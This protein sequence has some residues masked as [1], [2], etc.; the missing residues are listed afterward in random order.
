MLADRSAARILCLIASIGVG[1]SCL[2][3]VA[4]EAAEPAGAVDD[5]SL[6]AELVFWQSMKDTQN[7]EELRAYLGAYPEGRF[8][9][10]ARARLKAL[11]GEAGGETAG[12]TADR[13]SRMPKDP[14]PGTR[15]DT[16]GQA[17]A[18]VSQGP[19][20]GFRDCDGCPPMVVVPAG[21][22]DMG[23]NE[24]GSK[25]VHQV[26][27]QRP[28]AI[29]I[30]EVTVAQWE[31]CMTEGACR[32]GPPPGRQGNLPVANVSWEDAQSYLRWLS[33]K[34]GR[35]YR[36]PSEAEWEYAARAGTATRYWWGNEKAAGRANCADCGSPWDGRDASPVGSFQ[37]NPFGLFDVHG[38][39]W[40]WTQ[41]CWIETYQGAPGDG[42]PRLVGDCLSRVI[43][44]GSWALDHE[45][46]RSSRR[47]RY[48]R[49]VRYH[50]NG[51]RVVSE[52]PAAA[53]PAPADGN[54]PFEAAVLEAANRVFANA[55]AAVPGSAPET[56]VIDPLVDGLTGAES[57]ATRAIG[58]RVAALVRDRYAQFGVKDF[59]AASA[60]SRYVVV[61][62]FTGVN[63]QRESTGVREA[64][65]VCLR[66]LDLEAGKVVSGA[67]VFASPTGV[68]ITPTAFFRD[69]PVWL[70]DPAT[71]A[72]IDSCQATKPGDPVDRSYSDR[73]RAAALLKEAIDAYEKEEYGRSRDLFM[74]AAETKEGH[75]LRT[76][77]GLYLTSWKLGE[78]RQ[79]AQAFAKLVE[80]GLDNRRLGVKFPFS[81]GSTE[82]LAAAEA[83]GQPDLWLAQIARATAPRKDC[84]EIV[85]HTHRSAQEMLDQRL[86]LQRAEYVMRRLEAEAPELR[87]R[88][89]ATGKGSEESRIGTGTADARD[90]LDRRIE[91]DAIACSRSASEA[92]NDRKPSAGR[93]VTSLPPQM[94]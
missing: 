24:P 58:S 74:R 29:G 45:Y 26:V 6:Q 13:S 27:I 43:R 82:W 89:I 17:G 87:A 38:N 76:Y 81:P 33:A 35:T 18:S 62:T 25:P 79:A 21:R 47:S 15:A 65:R 88:M 37:P 66:L 34:T 3:V 56:V 10:L 40:E 68:D 83:D 61:G 49:D 2:G 55:P 91:L 57:V 14:L 5:L 69:S 86:S 75:Q 36:L 84:L 59:S 1:A 67:K 80:Y 77:N 12:E 44:G 52:L 16:G 20:T 64:Y 31:A 60:A 50:L 85:G 71:Q 51:F 53:G 63:K 70:A 90:A 39:V 46:M 23:S 73:I 30:H 54:L 4:A 28:F 42:T 7:P 93:A 78:R 22:F 48:D 9:S 32:Q 41:D 19:G 8:A 11:A 72:Y 94:R 92:A